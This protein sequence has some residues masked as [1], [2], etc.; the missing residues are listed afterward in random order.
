MTEDK[1]NLVRLYDIDEEFIIDL[2]YATENN[3]T[4]KSI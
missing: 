2:K 3:F 1:G 4:G